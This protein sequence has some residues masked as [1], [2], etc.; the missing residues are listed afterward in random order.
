MGVAG[1]EVDATVAGR[2]PKAEPAVPGPTP[3]TQSPMA[4]LPVVVPVVAPA[5]VE[6]PA[7]ALA[8]VVVGGSVVVVGASVGA[9][10]AEDS[11]Q[12][13]PRRS[14]RMRAWRRRRR[15]IVTAVVWGSGT[16][17]VMVSG[18]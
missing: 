3:A 4:V 5:P 18:S 12:V 11:A 1:A 9:G 14:G 6:P 8:D 10:V 13:A 16:G 7:G 2:L 15:E 17:P